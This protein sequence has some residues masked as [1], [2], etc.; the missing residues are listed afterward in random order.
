MHNGEDSIM[1]AKTEKSN[2]ENLGKTA[3]AVAL[4]KSAGKNSQHMADN[5][6]VSSS[7]TELKKLLRESSGLLFS[8][9]DEARS[10]DLEYFEKTK[11]FENIPHHR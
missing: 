7:Q 2:N 8:R 10:I 11:V 6:D 4:Q 3:M 5:R 9:Q 1:K